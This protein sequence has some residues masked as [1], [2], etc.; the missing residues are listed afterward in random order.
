MDQG[1]EPTLKWIFGQG[2][3]KLHPF[4]LSPL[5]N[6]QCYTSTVTVSNTDPRSLSL[7]PL[8]SGDRDQRSGPRCR[9]GTS[10]AVLPGT[11]IPGP[12]GDDQLLHYGAPIGPGISS[13]CACVWLV[14]L[15]Y[16]TTRSC[17]ETVIIM[18]R[19]SGAKLIDLMFVKSY[20]IYYLTR[21]L[22][23]GIYN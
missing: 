6:D 12:T 3:P 19:I 17:P 16:T 10:P 23:S 18:A 2:F 21:D 7:W 9:V 14:S 20:P 22:S 1:S 4:G 15:L 11:L 5:I 13:S 8:A